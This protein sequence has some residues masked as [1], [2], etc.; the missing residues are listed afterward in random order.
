MYLEVLKNISVRR[1]SLEKC[2]CR[3]ILKQKSL[4]SYFLSKHFSDDRFQCLNEKFSS[5]LLEAVMLFH[6]SLMSF[7]THF[8]L[9]LLREEPTIYI[10]KSAMQKLVRKLDIDLQSPDNFNDTKTFYAG[11]FTKNTLTKL[12]SEG[13]IRAQLH[14]DFY[15][16]VHYYS[17]SSVGYIQGKFPLND[18]FICNASLVNV[19]ERAH[20]E[21]ENGRFF[22]E[23]FP[24]IM[25]GISTDDLYEEITD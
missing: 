13:D 25:N 6:S 4:K 15:D 8:N 5:P 11:T 2:A 12:L 16:V 3:V 20:A 7:F 22:S 23:L 18:P 24:D 10:L 1:L 14:K 21:W 19:L 17:K 9:L